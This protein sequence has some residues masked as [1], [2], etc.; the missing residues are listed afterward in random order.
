M[1]HI[2]PASTLAQYLLEM[3]NISRNGKIHGYY[4]NGGGGGE[5][6]TGPSR[7]VEELGGVNMAQF[8]QLTPWMYR[9]GRKCC[10]YVIH[11]L[12]GERPSVS[13]LGSGG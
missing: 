5:S 8:S 3:V 1:K 13:L 2:L 6:T 10:G 9:S 7:G 12:V 4:H 11:R